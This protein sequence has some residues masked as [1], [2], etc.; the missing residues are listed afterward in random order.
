LSY[1]ETPD[2]HLL[3][4]M[5]DEIA[6]YF[7]KVYTPWLMLTEQ[8]AIK[9][10]VYAQRIYDAVSEGLDIYK[11]FAQGHERA[12]EMAATDLLDTLQDN[13]TIK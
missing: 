12:I 2:K 7:N 1:S 6:S 8:E 13:Q 10:R 4:L 5:L 3:L 11:S 9:Y